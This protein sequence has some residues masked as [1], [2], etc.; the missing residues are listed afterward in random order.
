MIK[1]NNVQINGCHRGLQNEWNNAVHSDTYGNIVLDEEIN[2]KT[3][4]ETI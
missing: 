4:K 3:K 2:W 1:F